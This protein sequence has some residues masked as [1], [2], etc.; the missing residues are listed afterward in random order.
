MYVMVS[1][2]VGNKHRAFANNITF[3]S[4]AAAFCMLALKA[5]FLPNWKYLFVVCTAPY[6]L[7]LLFV[8]F[9]PESVRFHRVKGELD[10]AMAVFKRIAYWNKTVIPEGVSISPSSQENHKTTPLD[11]F[12][13]KKLFCITSVLSW[14]S[15]TGAMSFYC[16]Y[17]AAG[18]ISGHMYLDFV[19]ITVLDFPAS[20]MLTPMINNYGRKKCCMGFLFLG[21]ISCLGLGLTPNHGKLK[22]LRVALGMFGKTCNVLS[23]IAMVTWRMELYPT[24]IRGEIGGFTMMA[25]K[26][27]ATCSPW[28]VA[29]FAGSYE[30]GVFVLIG[31][32]MLVSVFLQSFLQETL[33]RNLSDTG[34]VPTKGTRQNVTIEG[35]ASDETEA[36]TAADSSPSGVIKFCHVNEACDDVS[37]VEQR[38]NLM[39]EEAESE[40]A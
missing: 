6:A 25:N 33:G 27:G 2:I 15:F 22:I 16:L 36:T 1:E 8:W 12:R 18:N 23:G 28:I 5:Y 29:W 10:E 40:T 39:K 19:L 9:V 31:G 7:V 34:E 26:I 4:V 30:G 17:Y 20:L 21:A 11:L 37:V 35:S 24:T 3:F 13:T 32:L 14:N 38:L